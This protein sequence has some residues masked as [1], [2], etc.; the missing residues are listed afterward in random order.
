MSIM[1]TTEEAAASF[2]MTEEAFAFYDRWPL[3]VA[4]PVPADGDRRWPTTC[5]GTHAGSC[6]NAAL[7]KAHG[8]RISIATD[9][10]RRAT[11]SA[12]RIFVQGALVAGRLGCSRVEHRTDR[13]ALDAPCAAHVAAYAE[14]SSHQEIANAIGVKTASVKL[15]LFRARRRLAGLLGRAAAKG[16]A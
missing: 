6:T 5:C 9:P 10:R 1:S 15:L 12:L 7:S 8:E 13:L 4:L 16:G 11:A 3:G 2:A 14:G